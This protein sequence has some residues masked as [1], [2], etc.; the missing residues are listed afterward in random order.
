M[1]FF[2]ILNHR[3]WL[4]Q[5]FLI[6]L[7]TYVISEVG[8]PLKNG[9]CV[10]EQDTSV[11]FCTQIVY[12]IVNTMSYAPPK[13]FD[14]NKIFHANTYVMAAILEL[15]ILVCSGPIFWGGGQG[16][17]QL[18]HKE[19]NILLSTKFGTCIQKGNTFRSYSPHYM[20]LRPLEIFLLLHCGDRL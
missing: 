3:K 9:Q 5:L 6:Y 16:D 8:K 11:K 15:T 7:N 19:V 10:P 4:R 20:G 17:Y 2:S 13:F 12:D 14:R 1:L 18:S